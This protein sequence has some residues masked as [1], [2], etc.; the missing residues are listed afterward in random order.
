MSL[1]DHTF[2]ALVSFAECGL[3]RS[4]TDVELTH[5]EKCGVRARLAGKSEHA[6]VD[7]ARR[8]RNHADRFSGY[9]WVVAAE[10][11][12]LRRMVT[13]PRAVPD[14][15][16]SRG[17]LAE[18]ASMNPKLAR[19]MGWIPPKPARRSRPKARR[20]RVEAPTSERSRGVQYV[21]CIACGRL[22]SQAAPCGCAGSQ[23]VGR[24]S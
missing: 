4:L 7:G 1:Q 12:V 21:A 19:L 11:G 8:L 20:R 24:P 22:S 15:G 14:S 5:L 16:G 10:G 17:V 9:D 3:E 13:K 2:A 6:L 18:L 23:N